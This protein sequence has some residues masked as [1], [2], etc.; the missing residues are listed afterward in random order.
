MLCMFD[1]LEVPTRPFRATKYIKKK[2][3]ISVPVKQ[4][5]DPNSFKKKKVSKTLEKA[6]KFPCW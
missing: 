5:S 6:R 1:T 3:S 2:P 4:E